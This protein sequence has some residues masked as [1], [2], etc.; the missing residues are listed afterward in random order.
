MYA[1]LVG[2]VAGTVGRREQIAAA[3][4]DLV[5]ECDGDRLTGNRLVEVA[6]KGDIRATSLVRPEG[7]TASLSPDVRGPT[8]SCHRIRENRDG[9]RHKLNWKAEWPCDL[10]ASHI[11]RLQMRHQ[12][13]PHHTRAW[14]RPPAARCRLS[15]PRLETGDIGQAQLAGKGLVFMDDAIENLLAVVD[16]IH[17][18]HS[19]HEMADAHQRDDKTVA[20]RLRQHSLAGIDQDN[21]QRRRRS[22]GRHIAGVLLVAGRVG[23][24]EHS[25]VGRKER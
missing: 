8:R 7:R 4:I 16:Q 2:D 18:V 11:D 25:T 14:W 1:E 15:A 9:P 13:R 19:Q 3:Y 23:D 22:T 10:V 24:D 20:A 17:L 5:G 6:I 12:G 21:R